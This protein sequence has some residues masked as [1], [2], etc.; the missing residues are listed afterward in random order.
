MHDLRDLVIGIVG[1]LLLCWLISDAVLNE[2]IYWLRRWQY[3]RR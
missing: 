2:V 3:R 1:V